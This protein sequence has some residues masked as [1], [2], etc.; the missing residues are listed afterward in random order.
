MPSPEALDHHCYAG[1]GSRT[2]WLTTWEFTAV[3]KE[4]GPNLAP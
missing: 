4:T 3:P 2:I 1:Y